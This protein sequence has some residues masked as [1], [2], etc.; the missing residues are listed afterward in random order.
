M[1]SKEPPSRTT[2][3][4]MEN[5]SR[6]TSS[7]SGDSY[8][9]DPPP[10]LLKH[11]GVKSSILNR[12][13]RLENSLKHTDLE[14]KPQQNVGNYI[15]KVI[16]TD[17]AETKYEEQQHQ[18][19][20]V[21]RNIRSVIEEE[22]VQPQEYVPRNRAAVSRRKEFSKSASNLASPSSL[23][24][25][26]SSHVERPS[27]HVARTP[28]HKE[29]GERYRELYKNTAAPIQQEVTRPSSH[30]TR[31][32]SRKESGERYRETYRNTVAPVLP[33]EP[34]KI[35]RN[36]RS[37]ST[38]PILTIES[39]SSS[40]SIQNL[41]SKSGAH[42]NIINAVYANTD[43]KETA[44]KPM[45]MQDYGNESSSS[46]LFRP[47]YPTKTTSKQESMQDYDDESSDPKLPRS[48]YSKRN[49]NKY[50]SRDGVVHQR[51]RNTEYPATEKAK[52]KQ[53]SSKKNEVLWSR[54]LVDRLLDFKGNP[55]SDNLHDQD[56]DF[57]AE[58][59]FTVTDNLHQQD[60]KKE[61]YGSPHSG[62]EGNSSTN[63]PSRYESLFKYPETEYHPENDR[64]EPMAHYLEDDESMKN[65]PIEDYNENERPKRN[66]PMEYHREDDETTVVSNGVSGDD[67]DSV[68][69]DMSYHGTQ[70]KTWHDFVP[71]GGMS[72]SVRAQHYRPKSF[73]VWQ[74]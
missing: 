37:K 7:F 53:Q 50:S 27:S 70:S 12:I 51:F 25:R 24:A 40:D 23:E 60:L 71:Q 35:Y 29:S 41:K 19:R 61:N 8:S 56:E 6:S 42:R 2:S 48:K 73:E 30:V 74:Q 72:I 34:N 18:S 20:N 63:Q 55:E 33:E 17:I 22:R 54:G 31:T 13:M 26:T 4:E 16:D 5:T 47:K 21:S 14:K 64:N 46:E 28:S 15:R 58:S 65:Q 38:E 59:D 36:N 49:V 62:N 68:V 39:L 1:F 44:S 66:N 52:E 32:Q 69:Y 67:E 10:K 11:K 3:A 9:E 45:L 57:T 43:P